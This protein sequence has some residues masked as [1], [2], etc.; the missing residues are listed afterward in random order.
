MTVMNVTTIE[1]WSDAN[2]RYL[3]MSMDLL[4][5]YL[6]RHI[7]GNS[8]PFDGSEIEKELADLTN[9]MSAPPALEEL[10][11]AFGLSAFERTIVLMCAAME[12]ESSFP[13]LCARAHGDT[14][15]PFPTFSLALAALP[16]P[17]WSVLAPSAP[18]RHWRLIELES[19]S[20]LVN[21]PLCID[22]R[23]MSYLMGVQHLDEKLNGFVQPVLAA[24][25]LVPSHRKLAE[26]VAELWG[27]GSQPGRLPVIELCSAEISQS[28]PIAAA[29]CSVL[30]LHVQSMSSQVLPIS[31]VE[32]ETIVRLW[33][34]ESTLSGNALI[35]DHSTAEP[36]DVAREAMID[37]VLETIGG[38]VIVLSRR[39]RRARQRSMESF[40]VG[41][42]SRDEQKALWS[43][44]LGEA[45]A[46]LDGQIE[47][48][49]SQFNLDAPAITSICER[50][51]ARS[52]ESGNQGGEDFNLLATQLWEACR[53]QTRLRLDNLAQRVESSACRDD[54]ILPTKQLATLDE[55]ARHVRHRETVFQEWG[56]AEKLSHGSGINALFVGDS[57]TGKKL[58]AEVLANEVERDL[59]RIDL[60]QVVN[61]YIGET[62][63]NLSRIFDAADE[64]DAI[65]LFD[66]A[67]SLF[68]KRREVEDS[69]DRYSNVEIS[70]LLQR[71]EQYR[72]LSILTL[73]KKTTIDSVFLSRFRLI[74]QFPFP[75]GRARASIWQ[76]VFPVET[77]TR[78]LDFAKLAQLKINGGQ[79]RNIAISAA[80]LA[81]DEKQPVLMQH[82][83]EAARIEYTNREKS[84]TDKEIRGWM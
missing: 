84:L 30:G 16:Q 42:P 14:Q 9:S 53:M 76:R 52:T 36:G 70:Y 33:K 62:E 37:R 34:R 1:N 15:R 66:E 17:H 77:P 21:S 71:M 29:A 50:V 58:A 73:K 74:V 20:S 60:S 7:D 32:L 63:K 61:K 83:A 28:L 65:L 48:L 25:Y 46:E 78:G 72:G 81:A 23:V 44:S 18:L 12:L 69:H 41:N 4:K 24:S 22:Q 10:C 49:V 35:L 2:Q 55:L 80:F 11:D 40:H 82:V 13:A 68:G 38:A 75:R 45:A 67:D 79:I 6:L 31:P 27:H 51:R 3:V 8:E 43:M 26:E 57:G 5:Q 59:Y 19:S 39:R 56:F 47:R 64:G 54:L